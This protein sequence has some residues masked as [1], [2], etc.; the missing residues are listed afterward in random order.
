MLNFLNLKPDV[1]GLDIS[2]SSLKIAK[3][4]RKKGFLNLA[5]FAK[6]DIAPGVIKDGE[7]QDEKSLSS[8]IAELVVKTTG[9]KLKTK[10]VVASLPE[11]KSFLQVIQLPK[12]SDEELKKS[13]RFE[14]ENYIPLPIDDV[15][16][17]FRVIQPFRNHLDHVDVLI[18][19]L[20]KKIVDPYVASIKQAGLMPVA[21]EIESQ[22][23]SRALVKNEIS[24]FPI[25]LIDFG[26]TRTSFIV[27]AGYS[28]RFT[29]SITVS[30]QN[31][32][33]SISKVMGV[34]V[35][36]AERLKQKYGLDIG[37]KISFKKKLKGSGFD[38]EVV[39]D[40]AIIDVLIPPIMDLTK[41]IKKYIDY[42]QTHI[43]HEH[44][45]NPASRSIKEIRL[46]GGGA[47]LKGLVDI[48]ALELQIPVTTGNPWINILPQP[49]KEVPELSYEESLSYTTAL[50]LALR[51]FR[52]H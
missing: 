28:L 22:A 31:L 40:K 23:V 51:G 3:L 5:S 19:A 41:Q 42:Y 24:P 45:A 48:L 6:K 43:G 32:T 13:V 36:E 4:K 2:D 7:I 29:S 52:S 39:E 16:L 11:E 8:V 35:L 44:F 10:Y 37:K 9:E 50:G 49:L 18:A 26:A 14:A 38:K 30:A 1:F 20:P 27:F 34:N 33:D 12:M 15:Y 21:M 17:D 47:N 25:L 46:C